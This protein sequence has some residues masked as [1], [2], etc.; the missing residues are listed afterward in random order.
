MDKIAIGHFSQK[1]TLGHK[2]TIEWVLTSSGVCRTMDL[3]RQCVVCMKLSGLCIANHIWGQDQSDLLY[4]ASVQ[5][6]PFRVRTL[7][8]SDILHGLCIASI[9]AI[10]WPC[11]TK[12]LRYTVAPIKARY[13]KALCYTVAPTKAPTKAF[14]IRWPCQVYKGQVFNCKASVQ[15]IIVGVRTCQI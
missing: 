11:Y 6:I 10:Q 5:Q 8:V 15:Q 13:T 4:R 12:A 3:S 2:E 7:S 9:L 1:L 14:A